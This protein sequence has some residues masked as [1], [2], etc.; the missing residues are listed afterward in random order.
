MPPKS[1]PPKR[2]QPTLFDTLSPLVEQPPDPIEPPRTFADRFAPP[3]PLAEQIRAS[4]PGLFGGLPLK[5][6][7]VVRDEPLAQPPKPV[8]SGGEKGKGRD[9]LDAVRTL[10]QVEHERREATPEEKERL[11]RFCGFG[12]VALSIFPDPVTGKYKDS[13]E[14]IGEEL[15]A[16]LS[17]DEYASA[18]RT[19]FNAF[20]TSHVV[21]S[22]MHQALDRLG[23]PDDALVLEPGAGIG[24]FMLPGKRYIGVE[25]DGISGRIAR[26]LHPEADIRIQDFQDTKLPELD[27][28]IGNVPFADVKL[29]HHGQKFSLH[30]YFFAKS[31]DALK[32]G[33][34]LALVTSHYTLDKQNAAIREYLAERAD[35]LGAIRLPS[36]AF[37]RE[38]TAVVTDIVFLRKRSLDEPPSHVADWLPA[39]PQE[40]D[41]NTVPINRYFL[42]HPEM[43]LGTLCGKDSLYG[44]GYSVLSN[45]D[46]TEQLRTAVDRLPRFEP[47]RSDA[48]QPN[49][50]LAFAPPPPERH[51]SEGSFFVREGRIHQVVDDQAQP[52]VYGGGELWANGALVGRRMGAL[53]ELRDLAR[54]VLQSQNEGWPDDERNKARIRLN[55][56]YDFFR[57]AHGP[58]NKTT[59][60]E[61]QTGTTRRMP[62]LVKFR[63]DPDAMLVMALEEYDEKAGTAK[64]APILLRNVVG[65]TSPVTTVT[66][67][68]EGLLVDCHC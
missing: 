23:V 35:F 19:T 18:K 38:G 64:K 33:G 48:Q 2:V 13:W 16:L 27:G 42:D 60:S 30:D 52:V 37:K 15:K 4:Q 21:I 56:A 40:I 61:T 41:G 46:L 5:E 31:V 65:K 45:G 24:R 20:Y 44:Q 29:D 32:P 59:F 49:P 8:T 28:V 58:I 36:D 66:T 17:P 39:E 10:L 34:V 62:N 47:A 25:K 22:A 54:R 57:S 26:A 63:E 12:P 68:E 67:A 50:P 51:I 7:A 6:G 55:R 11:A 9:I 1:T 53:I 14:A 43:V 3:R